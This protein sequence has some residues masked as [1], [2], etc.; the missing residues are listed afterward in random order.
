MPGEYSML[1][2]AAAIGKV[3]KAEK[4]EVIPNMLFHLRTSFI[5]FIWRKILIE[6]ENAC[7]QHHTHDLADHGLRFEKPSQPPAAYSLRTDAFHV[8][9]ALPGTFEL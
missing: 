9:I 7:N 5:K 1:D 6:Y 4:G 3:F 8:I 2:V